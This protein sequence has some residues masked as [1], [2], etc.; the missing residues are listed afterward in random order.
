MNHHLDSE[1]ESSLIWLSSEEKDILK[2]LA[3]DALPTFLSKL[4]AETDEHRKDIRHSMLFRLRGLQFKLID[5]SFFVDG[6]ELTQGQLG[7]ALNLVAQTSSPTI[8]TA[9]LFAKL[10]RAT[11]PEKSSSSIS[12]ERTKHLERAT[13]E[14]YQSPFTGKLI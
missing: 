6:V 13:H 9:D 8:S 11:Y 5:S 12:Y 10:L 1:E 2:K 4:V 7:I 14:L 3:K